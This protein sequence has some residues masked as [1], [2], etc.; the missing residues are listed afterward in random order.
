MQIYWRKKLNFPKWF[1]QANFNTSSISSKIAVYFTYSVTTN[2]SIEYFSQAHYC[3][4]FVIIS[5]VTSDSTID[6]IKLFVT[7]SRYLVCLTDLMKVLRTG[8]SKFERCIRIVI[9]TRR[10]LMVAV[11]FI[12]VSQPVGATYIVVN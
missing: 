7:G 9:I 11:V 8:A 10:N 1:I 3:S 4:S 5:L 2:S 6:C 12:F